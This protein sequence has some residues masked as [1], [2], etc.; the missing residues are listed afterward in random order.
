MIKAV[1]TLRNYRQSPRK[2]RVVASLIKNKKVND[3]L[4]LLEF[5]A[6]KAT[7]PILKLLNSAISNAKNKDISLDNLVV[8]GIRVDV[9]KILYRRMPR[10]RG[11]A[12]PIRKRTSHITISLAEKEIKNKTKVKKI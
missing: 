8:H 11:S 12:S 7:D 2:V 5:T 4:S 1:A 6:K 9:G 10:A 3:A